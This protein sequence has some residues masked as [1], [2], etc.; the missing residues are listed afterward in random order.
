[1]GNCNLIDPP[2]RLVTKRQE[3]NARVMRGELSG[4][5]DRQRRLAVTLPTIQWLKK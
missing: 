1:M 5:T 4:E 3:D 2:P